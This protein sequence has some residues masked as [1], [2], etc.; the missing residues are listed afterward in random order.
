MSRPSKIQRLEPSA[1]AVVDDMIAEGRWTIDE[2]R[3][4]LRQVAGDATPSRAAVGAYVKR[5]RER[6]GEPQ[7]TLERR[8][9]AIV[10]RLNT[11]GETLAA[12]EQ[13]MDRER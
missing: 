6:A 8:L 10:A 5:V 7:P 3:A 12:L 9:D 13:A 4:A 11:I 2:I 1:R